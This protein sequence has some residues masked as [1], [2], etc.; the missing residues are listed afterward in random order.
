MSAQS[1]GQKILLA[2]D[3][4]DFVLDLSTWLTKEGFRT[5]TVELGRA[6]IQHYLMYRPYAA[7]VL[8]LHMPKVDGFQVLRE[9]KRADATAKVIVL[10]ADDTARDSAAELGADAF[11]V[12]PITREA[13]CTLVASVANN[14]ADAA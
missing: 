9:I 13:F 6:A 14:A 7:V 2:D 8:D 5:T 1:M 11:V 12:K 10:T 3:D 4:H